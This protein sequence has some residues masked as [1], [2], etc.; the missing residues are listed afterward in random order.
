MSDDDGDEH[1]NGQ[2]QLESGPVPEAISE[3]LVSAGE[4]VRRATSMGLDLAPETLPIVDHYL[5]LSR[6]ELRGRGELANLV[7][8]AIGA[9]FGEVVRLR[10]GG[11]WFIPS[12]NVQDWLVCAESVFLSFNP[13]GV[14]FDALYADENHPGP[15][16][17]LRVAPEYRASVDAR[18]AELPEVSEDEYFK[19]TTRFEV[20]EITVDE[21]LA[22]MAQAG[23][24]DM[25]F[26]LSDYIQEMSPLGDA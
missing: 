21:L 26:Q 17:R 3:L 18:L 2:P 19:L 13:I 20:I 11:F 5:D 7:G 12:P 14:A 25:E 4:Y 16:S 10:F 24:S 1:D 8:R 6:T 22:R 23:Y 15:A 9:Y